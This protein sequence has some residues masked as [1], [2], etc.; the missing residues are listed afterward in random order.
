MCLARSLAQG[1]DV[2]SVLLWLAVGVGVGSGS[3]S[4]SGAARWIEYT[5]RGVLPGGC[6]R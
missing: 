4:G 6:T 3:G 2:D 5:V 1:V